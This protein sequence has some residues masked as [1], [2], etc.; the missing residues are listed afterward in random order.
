MIKFK[1]LIVKNFLSYGDNPTTFYL[2]KSTTTLL[3]GKNG[4]GKSCILDALVFSLFGTSFRGIKK[5]NLINSV[6]QKG[7]E[8]SITFTKGN[9]EYNITRGIKPNTLIVNKNGTNLQE[10]ASIS[11]SQK[12]IENQILGFDANTFTRVCIMSTM[13]Y[14]P[15]M[16]LPAHLRRKFVETMLDI[17]LFSDMSV[18]HKAEVSKLK[19]SAQDTLSFIEKHKIQK[20]SKEELL[21]YVEKNTDKEIQSIKKEIKSKLE[22][23]ESLSN[24]NKSKQKEI[25]KIAPDIEKYNSKIFDLELQK[26]N[27]RDEMSRYEIKIDNLKK[28]VDYI[29]S[30][31]NCQQCKRNI[32]TSDRN[33]IE[34]NCSKEILDLENKLNSV[35]NEFNLVNNEIKKVFSEYEDLTRKK[36]NL[37]GIIHFNE[38]KIKDEKKYIINTLNKKLNELENNNKTDKDK[39]VKEIMDLKDSIEKETESYKEIIED[40]DVSSVISEMLKDTGIKSQIINQYIPILCTFI[41]NYLSKLNINVTFTMDENFNESIKTRYTDELEYK[42]LSAGERQ[43]VDLA[44]AFAWR[45]VAKLKGSVNTNILFLD[46]ILDASLDATGTTSALELIE[47]IANDGTSVFIVSHKSNLEEAVQSVIELEKLNG[48]TKLKQI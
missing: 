46:E 34:A 41:N 4:S 38:T 33:S 48:F 14:V 9:D 43:R 2:D 18:L 1:K 24:D 10:D 40:I 20:K 35:T 11:D 31:D 25:D 5:N 16:E 17:Q 7:C 29:K 27:Y 13:N 15:F 21:S 32:D 26:K 44:I 12:F 23:I 30:H 39:I 22:G 6:N 47:S 8:V 28:T 36:K 42:N 3:S 45:A 19:Q 37:N